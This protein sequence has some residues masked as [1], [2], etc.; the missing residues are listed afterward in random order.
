M[1]KKEQQVNV[2]GQTLK[3][4]NLDKVMYPE[5]GTTKGEVLDYLVRAAPALLPHTAWR[6]ATRKRWV[7]GVGTAENPGQVFFRKDLED[8]APDWLPRAKIQHQTHTNTYPL[9]NDEAALAWAGQMAALELHV[10]QWRFDAS[11][12][13]QNPDRMVLDLD[14]GPGAELKHCVEAAFLC[15]EILHGMGLEVYPVTSGSKGIHLY[16][17]LDGTSTS[18]EVNEVAKELARSLEHEHPDLIVANMRRSLRE[19]KVLVDWSQNNGSKTTVA[20][21]SLRGKL[22]PTVAAP[23][24]WK[25]LEAEDLAQL[26]YRAVLDRLDEGIDPLADLAASYRQEQDKLA[27]YRAKRDASA[28]PEP[29]PSEAVSG[30]TPR[31]SVKESSFVIQEHHARALHWD[32]RLEHDGVFVSWAVP[33]GPPLDT[34]VQ[35]L[36]VMTEDHPLSYGGFEGTIPKGQYGAGE[37]KIWD[38]GTCVIEKWRDGQEVIAV[39]TGAPDGGLGGVP[40]RYV[41]VHAH[42]MGEKNNW[43]L[44]L[45]KDQ[46]QGVA[47]T[48]PAPI[49]EPPKPMLAQLG[50]REDLAEEDDWQFEMKW[51]GYRAIAMVHDGQV[52][53]YSRNGKHLEKDFPELQELAE[54]AGDG[55]ILD[56]EIVAL[57]A[58]GRPSFSRLQQRISHERKKARRD[59][60]KIPLRLMLFDALQVL[61]KGK[62]G[63]GHHE[64]LMDQPY[65]TRRRKLRASVREGKHIKIPES[66][67]GSLDKALQRSLELDLEGIVAKTTDSNYEAGRRSE[68]WIKLKHHLHQEVIVIGWRK[69]NGERRQSIGSLLLAVPQEGELE[70]VG[71]VGTGFSTAELS[72][73]RHRLE[74][75][76]R[77]TPPVRGIPPRFLRDVHWVTPKYV[78]EVQYSELTSDRHLRHPVWR[79]WREDKEPAEVRWE[80]PSK[81]NQ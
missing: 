28:T 11:L 70:F 4:S 47:E 75:I 23:R 33:K 43:L 19:G 71:R 44:Q 62:N 26:D 14:P 37:V 66:F 77:K 72:E 79:G 29:V 45:T 27:L 80:Q 67:S 57:D 64:N 7:N 60:E 22:H 32:F 13:Q 21:Y 3:V 35:R 36:A 20:P 78:A 59:A 42:G 1:A 12:K 53:L 18:D 5:T 9:I 51:D 38:S 17:A 6:P 46:P 65:L 10:P 40:R 52:V 63:K 15:R 30:K 31:R 8:S 56:G 55:S 50:T 16:A 41:L 58:Q 34:G 76:E 68:S 73:I 24:T 25:E 54:L 81:E 74:K 2:A 49:A 69:G 61:E 39:L 48:R